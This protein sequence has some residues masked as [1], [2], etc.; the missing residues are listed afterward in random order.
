MI[1]CTAQ[2][3]LYKYSWG[4]YNYIYVIYSGRDIGISSEWVGQLGRGGAMENAAKRCPK[5]KL[6]HA[7]IIFV[8]TAPALALWPYI[9]SLPRPSSEGC[10]GRCL[11]IIGRWESLWHASSPSLSGGAN[12]LELTMYWCMFFVFPGLYCICCCVLYWFF[13]VRWNQTAGG[14]RGIEAGGRECFYYAMLQLLKSS[15]R[16]QLTQHNRVPA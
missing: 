3:V 16:D 12:P 8:N 6:W 10:P 15:L 4:L 7:L 13:A 9:S 14:G 11:G 5:V 1:M 2:R